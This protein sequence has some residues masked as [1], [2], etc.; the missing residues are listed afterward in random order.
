[1]TSVLISMDHL[2]PFCDVATRSQ[3]LRGRVE[4]ISQQLATPR[5]GVPVGW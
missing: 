3:E 2:V 1:M 4:E 5:D